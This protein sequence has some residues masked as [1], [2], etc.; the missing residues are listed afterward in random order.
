MAAR[1]ICG[2]AEH[3]FADVDR[4]SGNCVI[5]SLAT[6]APR[7][8]RV[9]QQRRPRAA[10]TSGASARGR[11]DHLAL[12]SRRPSSRRGLGSKRAK[13]RLQRL[14]Q[15]VAGRLVEAGNIG[16]QQKPMRPSSACPHACKHPRAPRTPKRPQVQ[17]RLLVLEVQSQAVLAGACR[18]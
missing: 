14:F 6:V 3:T 13:A 15:S 17:L 9:W 1:C 12:P 10:H 16:L 7:H 18:P 5:Q 2:N 4:G 11:S 8:P